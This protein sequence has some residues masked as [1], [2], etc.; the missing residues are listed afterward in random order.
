MSNQHW[1]KSQTRADR[2]HR[3][4][5]LLRF[6]D[7]LKSLFPSQF[8]LPLSPGSLSPS[9]CHLRQHTQQAPNSYITGVRGHCTGM[10][11]PFHQQTCRPIPYRSALPPSFLSQW[12]RDDLPSTWAQNPEPGPLSLV[13]K[14]RWAVLSGPFHFSG[15]RLLPV[16]ISIYLCLPL[17]RNPLR[18]SL[19]LCRPTFSKNGPHSLL[20]PLKPDLYPQ[21]PPV[22][23]LLPKSPLTFLLLN[24]VAISHLYFTSPPTSIWRW[25][26]LMPYFLL[27]PVATNSLLFSRLYLSALFL[28]SCRSL[29]LFC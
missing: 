28:L 22:K 13:P 25:C 7:A 11:L 26:P 17:Q 9:L 21:T 2:F 24:P 19:P 20:S 27:A 4:R 8:N 12:E 6:Q 29:F 1:R 5:I 10:A 23:P 16:H 3:V 14:S 15:Y 18:N